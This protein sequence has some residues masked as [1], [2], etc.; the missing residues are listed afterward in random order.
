MK[1]WLTCFRHAFT[2]QAG[3]PLAVL[4]GTLLFSSPAWAQVNGQPAA[5]PAPLPPRQLEEAL[6]LLLKAD[7]VRRLPHRTGME[8]EGL[9]LDQTLTKLGRDFYEF[10]YGTFQPPMGLDEYTIIVAERPFRGNNS[11]ITI[12]VNEQELL[13][14]PLPTRADQ[15][16]EIVAGAVGASRDYL[17]QLQ[18]VSKQLDEGSRSPP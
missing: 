13:E 12:K 15:M 8:A 1:A 11:I 17:D 16:E 7:S 10:F 4:A 3:R 14:M 18:A 9:V 5:T 6:R 2:S